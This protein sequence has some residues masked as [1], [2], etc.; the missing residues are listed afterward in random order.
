MYTLTEL[1]VGV[2]DS[3][4]AETV[5]AYNNVTASELM[6][7]LIATTETKSFQSHVSDIQLHDYALRYMNTADVSR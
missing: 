3:V 5:I 6:S 2:K 7:D 4:A 1:K